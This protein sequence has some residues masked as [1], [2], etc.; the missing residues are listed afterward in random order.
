M[1]AI[2]RQADT[3]DVPALAQMMASIPLWQRYG[4]TVDS[5]TARFAHGLANAATILVAEDEGGL[6]GFVWYVL[7]GAF[8]RSGYVMLIGVAEGTQG[9]GVGRLLMESAEAA[10]FEAS[11]AVFLLVSG[12]NLS[13]QRFYHQR[14]YQQIGAIPD[15][16]MPGITELILC[17]RRARPKTPL[18]IAPPV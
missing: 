5:A 14:G 11:D 8:Q 6:V 4:V 3:G 12:F 7:R 1:P 9:Q 18:D 15:Y 10:M 16:V 2:I 13:T 17:K